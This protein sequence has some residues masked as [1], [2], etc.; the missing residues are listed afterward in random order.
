MSRFLSYCLFTLG[1]SLILLSRASL[2]VAQQSDAAVADPPVAAANLPEGKK[3]HADYIDAI[4]GKAAMEKIQSTRSVGEFSTA[5]MSGKL[6][7]IKARPN[8]MTV[9]VDLGAAKAYQGTNGEIAWDINPMGAARILEGAQK[10]ESMRQAD[11]D[12]Q[13]NV[14]KYYKSMTTVGKEKVDGSDCYKVEFVGNNDQKELRYY[15]V[16]SKLLRRADSKVRAPVGQI[17][18]EALL[19]DYRKVGETMLPFSTTIKMMG[20][21]QVIKLLEVEHNIEITEDTFAP[22]EKIAK[23]LEEKAKK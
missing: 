4:G 19:T 16:E 15:D 14:E 1:M 12:E 22:P 10:E 13:L 11:F 9:E 8:K 20:T 23:M 3:I 18:V 21:E 17:N 7:V 5:G 6:I 2:A